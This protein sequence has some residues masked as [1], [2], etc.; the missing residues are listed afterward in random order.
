MNEGVK[1]LVTILIPNF[2]Y[3]R[4]IDAT[5]QSVL[6]QTYRPLE[7]IVVDDGSTDNSRQIIDSFIERVKKEGIHL[8]D[9]LY[10][11]KNIGTNG[12]LNRVI[13]LINGDVTIILDSD[14]SIFPQYVERTI[15]A[16]LKNKSNGVGFV[17]TDDIL[18][19]ESGG[20]LRNKDGREVRLPFRDFDA[21]LLQTKSYIPG[22]AAILTD[23]L[24]VVLPLEESIRK[25][26]KHL[27]WKKIVERGY[28]GV[29]ISEQLFFYRMHDNNNSGIGVDVKD[30][31]ASGQPVGEISDYWKTT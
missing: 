3:G 1:D 20:V 6:Q 19:N 10:L 13:P 27:R 30:K 18:I 12:A 28:K 14:D 15:S 22:C 5:L 25:H 11:A 2:N 26:T 7:L 24:K 31:I 9:P 23:A 16:L 8:R 21:E 29:H 17:Y 4:F